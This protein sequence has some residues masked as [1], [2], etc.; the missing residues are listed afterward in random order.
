MPV[1]CD[2]AI[3]DKKSR[4]RNPRPNRRMLVRESHL[5]HTVDVPDGVAISVEHHRRHCLLLLEFLN[6]GRQMMDLLLQIAWRRASCRHRRV[7][8]DHGQCAHEQHNSQHRLHH[9]LPTLA[10]F[11]RFLRDH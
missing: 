1:R 11:V 3:S 2:Q 6:L 5:I 10:D 7:V 8:V 9:L 4:A